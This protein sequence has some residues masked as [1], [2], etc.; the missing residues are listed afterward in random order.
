[1]TAHLEYHVIAENPGQAY[2]GPDS[3]RGGQ[4]GHA[5]ESEDQAQHRLP[6]RAH[7]VTP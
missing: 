4:Q 3:S 5:N 6:G 2:L 1:M 7:R